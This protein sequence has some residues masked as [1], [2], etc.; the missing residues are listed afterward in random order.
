MKI[1]FRDSFVDKL[2]R[3]VLYISEDK[4]SAARKFKNDLLDKIKKLIDQPYK[5]R[6]SIYF[7]NDQIRDLTFKGYTIVYK[8]DKLKNIISVFAMIKHEEKIKN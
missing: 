6:R 7:E 5:N 4:P 3:Q 2:N 8:V 1:E